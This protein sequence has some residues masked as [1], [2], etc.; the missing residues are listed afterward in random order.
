MSGNSFSEDSLDHG[1][2]L[3]RKRIR[4]TTA[5]IDGALA[6]L[7]DSGSCDERSLGENGEEFGT[8]PLR[9]DTPPRRNLRASMDGGLRGL[10]GRRMSLSD[11]SSHDRFQLSRSEHASCS[12]SSSP[13]SRP[14]RG[15]LTEEETS[16]KR[17]CRMTR[18]DRTNSGSVGDCPPRRPRLRRT[19]N[20]R[21]VMRRRRSSGSQKTFRETI[22]TERGQV[23]LRVGD[24][25]VL[26]GTRELSTSQHLRRTRP[27]RT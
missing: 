17:P 21:D 26:R 27:N 13:P 9:T 20:S 11:H 10:S 8:M 19:E 12:L 3:D 15:G 1:R 2:D 18:S 5:C 16:R 7:S 25:R 6:I 14:S 22:T 23:L 4:V 24:D